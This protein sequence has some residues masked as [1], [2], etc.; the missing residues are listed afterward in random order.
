M[1]SVQ[2]TAWPRFVREKSVFV[3]M[4]NRGEIFT[5]ISCRTRKPSKHKYVQ[6]GLVL[7]AYVAESRNE[8][9]FLNALATW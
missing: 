6:T 8:K 3:C 9:A 7:P 2:K 5:E 1:S 4:L